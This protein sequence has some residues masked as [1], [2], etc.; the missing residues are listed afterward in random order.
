ML[1]GQKPFGNNQSQQAIL[2]ES[3]ILNA[4]KVV[5]PAKPQVSEGAKE[6]IQKCLAYHQEDRYDVFEAYFSPYLRGNNALQ[7]K[8]KARTP[9]QESSTQLK[10]SVS[11]IA[12][13]TLRN[14]NE[15]MAKWG[16]ME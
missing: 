5:F 6:F 14:V 7:V 1:Y 3:T 15:S 8:P 13:E 10:R 2:K 16:K 11:D 9:V 4:H 12:E